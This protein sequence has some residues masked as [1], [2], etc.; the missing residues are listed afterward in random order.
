MG[1]GYV[2]LVD[3]DTR[4]VTNKNFFKIHLVSQSY[5][6]CSDIGFDALAC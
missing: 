3:K 2:P 1:F 4:H 6:T 5:S